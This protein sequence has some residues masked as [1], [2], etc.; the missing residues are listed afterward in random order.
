LSSIAIEAIAVTKSFGENIAVNNINL[1]IKEGEFFSFLGPSGCGKTT[2]LRMIAGFERPT[3]GQLII[4]GKDMV[5]IPPHKRPVNLVFQSYALFPHMTVADNVAF[6]LKSKGTYN[7]ADIEK[8]AKEALELVRLGPL[9]ERYPSQLSGGQQQRVALARAAVNKPKV[10]LLDEPL[11]A[12]DPQIREEMQEELS[13]LQ[14]ELNLT[15]VMVTHDQS[16]ALALSHRLAV[17]ARG[18]LEQVGTPIEIYEQPRTV[19]VAQFIG[20]TNLIPGTVRQVKD[21][22]VEIDVG[23]GVS[24]WSE[25]T[26]QS[27]RVKNGDDVILFVKPHA[28]TIATPDSAAPDSAVPEVKPSGPHLVNHFEATVA[29]CSY[30]GFITEYVVRLAGGTKLKVAHSNQAENSEHIRYSEGTKVSGSFSAD[31]CS[32]FRAAEKAGNAAPVPLSG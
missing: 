29:S 14:R 3:S 6:G 22:L 32:F 11:S 8:M 31:V 27:E 4:D 23:S 21:D 7:K 17:F 13:R 5:M 25:N 26:E 10:L 24:L 20:Q 2:L 18:N 12:L 30:Q 19:F 15:F 16:E 9:S 1:T 28:V